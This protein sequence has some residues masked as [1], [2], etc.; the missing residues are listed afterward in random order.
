MTCVPL[1]GGIYKKMTYFSIPMPKTPANAYCSSS[2]P[3]PQSTKDHAIHIPSHHHH[4]HYSS[5]S[6]SLSHPPSKSLL[7]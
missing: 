5:V 7:I 3:P 1:Y 4:Y 2:P 6:L